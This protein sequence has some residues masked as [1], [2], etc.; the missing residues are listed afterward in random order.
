MYRD[1]VDNLD[2]EDED[3]DEYEMITSFDFDVL[4]EHISCFLHT[5]Q[6]MVKDGLQNIGSV[7]STIAKASKMVSYVR[8]SSL[9][10]DLLDGGPKFQ[11]K[12]DTRW[13]R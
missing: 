8:K 5:L 6:L 4:G 1:A 13:N 12:N 2:I 10:S 9:A 11:V 7:S 3:D